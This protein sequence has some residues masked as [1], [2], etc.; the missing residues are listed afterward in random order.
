MDRPPPT[1]P[2]EQGVG[3]FRGVD[4]IEDDD[5]HQGGHE[6]DH[7]REKHHGGVDRGVVAELWRREGQP[8]DQDEVY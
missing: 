6:A 4:G 3:R 7:G 8:D 1:R 5:G 2:T